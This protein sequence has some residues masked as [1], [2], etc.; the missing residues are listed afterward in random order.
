MKRKKEKEKAAFFFI[1][2]LNLRPNF[3]KVHTAA[4][5]GRP[6][7]WSLQLLMLMRE[8]QSTGGD[9]CGWLPHAHTQNNFSL[10]LL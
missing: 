5:N 9:H 1:F 2:L 7:L 8:K 3:L 10:P 4:Y 6:E